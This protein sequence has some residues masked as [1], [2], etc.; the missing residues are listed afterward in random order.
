[1]RTI[2]FATTN[3]DKVKEIDEIM[4]GTD[5]QILQMKDIGFDEDIDETGTT[6]TE[7]AAIKAKAVADYIADKKKD[8]MDAIVMADDSGLEIDA[9]GKMPGVQSHRWLGDRTYTQAMQDIIDEIKD[10]PEEKRTARFVCSI[11]A[12]LPG[13][14]DVITVLETVE[15]MVAH[16]IAGENGFGYDPFFYVPEFGCT[17]AQMTSE[18]KNQISHRGKAVRAIRDKLVGLKMIEL[19]K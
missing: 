18:Q 9:L 3:A 13:K 2:I 4:Q 1:M 15:G 12:A 17:T 10:V 11:A 5:T 8:F 19:S 7:N 16:E 14:E 6:F